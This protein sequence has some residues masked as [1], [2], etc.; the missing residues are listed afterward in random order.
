MD[1]IEKLTSPREPFAHY[2]GRGVKVAIIDSGVN[3]AHPHVR[4][5]AGGTRIASSEAD[6]PNDYLDYIGHGTAVAGAIR[7]KAPDA[8]LYAVKVFDRALTTNIEAIIKS[9]DWCIENQIEVINLSL[10]TV[11]VEHRDVIERAVARAAENGA[12]LVAAREMSGQPSLP[13]CLPSVIGVAADW[14]CPRDSYRVHCADDDPVFVASA[15]PREIPGVPRERN[16]N[17]M[18]FAVAN[19][20]GFV[21]RAWEFAAD[22]SVDQ[23]KRLLVEESTRA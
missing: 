15:Y 20:A 2:T 19:M 11:N 21:T 18:S 16:L 12:V 7:E 17:G 10:G 8:L 6:S 5:V 13:G 14:E 22:A 9:I 4:G 3:P 23:L 1:T